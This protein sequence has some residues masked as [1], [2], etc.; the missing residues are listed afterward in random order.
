MIHH[1]MTKYVEDVVN[2]PYKSRKKWSEL[3]G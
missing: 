1:Y 3:N 2:T